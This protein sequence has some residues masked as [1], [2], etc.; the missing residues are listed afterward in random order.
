M[1][2]GDSACSEE[3]WSARRGHLAVLSHMWSIA[4]DRRRRRER[5][6]M[7]VDVYTPRRQ[8]RLAEEMVF[9]TYT[10]RQFARLLGRLARLELVETYNFAYNIDRPIQVDGQVEVVVYVLRKK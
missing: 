10:A 5:L 1:V 7:T 8:F 4:V 6:G 3:A 2:Y 9:R